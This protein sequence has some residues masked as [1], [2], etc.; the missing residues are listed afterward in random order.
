MSQIKQE[1]A[2]GEIGELKFFSGS[3]MVP[4]GNVERVKKLE[5]GGGGL[6]DIGIYPIQLACLMFN[7]EKPIKITCTGHLMPTGVDECCTVTLLFPGQRIASINV[8]TNV[9]MFG[10][11]HLIGTKGV[12]E[13]GDLY[14]DLAKL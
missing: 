13:V 11:T 4:V 14:L 12:L 8:S 10:A 9:T 6:L 7:H 1:I 2:N 5:L 3:F